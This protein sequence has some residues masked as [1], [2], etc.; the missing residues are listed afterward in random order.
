M[1]PFFFSL[2]N[3]PTTDRVVCVTRTF[4]S[5]AWCPNAQVSGRYDTRQPGSRV[6]QLCGMLVHLVG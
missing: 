5:G 1:G 4:A 3:S 2:R 6:I